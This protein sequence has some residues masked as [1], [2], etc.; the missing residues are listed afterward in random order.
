MRHGSIRAAS[1]RMKEGAIAVMKFCKGLIDTEDGATMV[2]YGL[3]LA[4]IGVV[5]AAGVT[6]L[7]T[8][9]N[10]KFGTAST[11]VSKAGGS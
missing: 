4:L 5:V 3:M 7:G 9:L 6:T 2:E 10:T 1:R 8:T 11:A